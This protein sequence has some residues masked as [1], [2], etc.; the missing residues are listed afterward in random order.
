MF[1][2]A[3]NDDG[4]YGFW[5][6]GK[7]GWFEIESTALSYGSLYEEMAVAASM[8]Y[9]FADK[10]RRANKNKS[11][12]T[13]KEVNKYM[14]RIFSDVRCCWPPVLM[15][16]RSTSKLTSPSTLTKHETLPVSQM[17]RMCEMLSM[18]TVTF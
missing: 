12:L 4:T 13:N 18:T 3:D 9:M 6:A 5:A 10:C 7:A 17:P 14:K 2:Y 16:L 1:A 8:L 11:N 15:L